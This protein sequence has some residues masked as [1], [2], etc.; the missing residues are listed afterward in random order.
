MALQDIII[1]CTEN[2]YR[3]T[4]SCLTPKSSVGMNAY[5][6][7]WYTYSSTSWNTVTKLKHIQLGRFSDGDGHTAWIHDNYLLSLQ[8]LSLKVVWIDFSTRYASKVSNADSDDI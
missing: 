2:G 6:P 1:E 3:F 4:V 8:I 7:Q 5:I